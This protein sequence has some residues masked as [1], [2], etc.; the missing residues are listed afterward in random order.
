[1]TCLNLEFLFFTHRIYDCS[2][3]DHVGR[4]R[5]PGNGGGS[6][7][8]CF[9]SPWRLGFFLAADCPFDRLDPFGMT[10]GYPSKAVRVEK[11]YT[12]LQNKSSK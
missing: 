4:A 9:F 6:V 1:M 8:F 3:V 10:C 5:T 2:L 12:E 11:K 7:G